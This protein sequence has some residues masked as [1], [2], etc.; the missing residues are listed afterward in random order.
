M[1]DWKL[2]SSEQSNNCYAFVCISV[3]VST[4]SWV[5]KSWNHEKALSQED[6]YVGT[7]VF[8]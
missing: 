8:I 4:F 7:Y 5:T 1:D 3:T 6:V 2:E